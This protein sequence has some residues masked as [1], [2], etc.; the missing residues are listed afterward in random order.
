MKTTK[1]I[2]T[3]SSEPL[4]GAYLMASAYMA[5]GLQ[6]LG[7]DGSNR[8]S[9]VLNVLNNYGTPHTEMVE[10][11][12]EWVPYLI[13]LTQAAEK[14]GAERSGCLHY[15]VS[16]MFGHWWGRYMIGQSSEPDNGDMPTENVARTKLLELVAQFYGHGYIEA[17]DPEGYGDLRTTL[18]EVGFRDVEVVHELKQAA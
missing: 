2:I 11:M 13:R 7:L 6:S 8:Y 1:T 15:E 17:G 3:T 16:E 10:N 18:E 4:D 12:N 5:Y 14:F 9:Q